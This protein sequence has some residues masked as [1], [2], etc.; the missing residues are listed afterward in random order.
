MKKTDTEFFTYARLLV[1][2]NLHISKNCK[3][4]YKAIYIFPEF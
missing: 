2:K 4:T 3:K 1:H